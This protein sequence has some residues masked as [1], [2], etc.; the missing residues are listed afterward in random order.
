M[1]ET[2][3]VKLREEVLPLSNLQLTLHPY[4]LNPHV[5]LAVKR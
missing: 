1:T 4:M 5:I 3:G 2:L